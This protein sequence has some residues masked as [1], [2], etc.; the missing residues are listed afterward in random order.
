[1]EKAESLPMELEGE[2][3]SSHLG[4]VVEK[5][6]PFSKT[7]AHK[8]K[9]GKERKKKTQIENFPNLYADQETLRGESD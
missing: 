7:E 5:I 4:I 2:N 9:R 6:D 3:P 8:R 1:M